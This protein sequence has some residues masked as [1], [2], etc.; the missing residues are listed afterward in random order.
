[1]KQ[2]PKSPLNLLIATAILAGHL[3]SLAQPDPNW[4]IHDRNRP[5]PPVV[6]PGTFSSQEQPGRP[7]SD[8]I[9]L[10]D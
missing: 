6:E 10:F 1:M 2:L 3:T 9:V 5:L 7:P 4:L 8:A